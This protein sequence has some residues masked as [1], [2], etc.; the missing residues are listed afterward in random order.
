MNMQHERIGALCARL[1]LERI[2][3]DWGALAQEAARTEASYA[4]FLERLLATQVEAAAA[5]VETSEP[6]DRHFAVAL[7]RLLRLHKAEVAG[8]TVEGITNRIDAT[9][10]DR[11]ANLVDECLAIAKTI[12]TAPL[13]TA[14]KRVLVLALYRELLMMMDDPHKKEQET[15]LAAADCR[16]IV[17]GLRTEMVDDKRWPDPAVYQCLN[18][19]FATLTLEELDLA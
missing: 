8:H 5:A 12:G 10:A 17:R 3:R 9:F 18:H 11:P 7:G 14:D 16:V 6:R 1:K 4:D 15:E 2:E 13:A 19:W